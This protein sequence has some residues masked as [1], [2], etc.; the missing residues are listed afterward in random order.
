M[1]RV[2]PP[3]DTFLLNCDIV[4]AISIEILKLNGDAI[5]VYLGSLRH[6]L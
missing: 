6:G 1:V 3:K 5:I 2:D 4:R